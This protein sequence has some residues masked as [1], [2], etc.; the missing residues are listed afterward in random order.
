M[1]CLGGESHEHVL[2]RR[3]NRSNVGLMDAHARQ[4]APNGALRRALIDEQM[5]RLP[6]HG[7][8]PDARSMAQGLKADGHVITRY[9]EPPRARWIDLGHRFQIVWDAADDQFG[10]V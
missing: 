9:V 2:Q 4:L 7:C 1:V 5:H 6:E 3:A 8:A 10:S